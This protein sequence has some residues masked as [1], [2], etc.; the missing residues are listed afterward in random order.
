[1]KERKK[2]IRDQSPSGR[3]REDQKRN[4]AVEEEEGIWARQTNDRHC[5]RAMVE[6]GCMRV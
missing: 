2:K 4:S 1:M 5:Q 3:G 6:R